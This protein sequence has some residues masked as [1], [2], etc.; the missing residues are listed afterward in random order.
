M[1]TARTSDER[2][3]RTSHPSPKATNNATEWL[4]AS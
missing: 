2:A 4:D 1:A 3:A